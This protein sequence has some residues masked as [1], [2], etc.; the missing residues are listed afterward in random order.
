[1]KQD[2]LS[3][4]LKYILDFSLNVRYN[5]LCHLLEAK[6]S[7]IYLSLFIA[8]LTV[9]AFSCSPDPISSCPDNQVL[10][11]DT[12]ECVENTCLNH[13]CDSHQHCI[14]N[15]SGPKCI[16]DNGY[17]A[18]IEYIAGNEILTCSEHNN[19]I[20]CGQ[21]TDSNTHC[22]SNGEW[23]CNDG[24]YNNAAPGEE[25]VCITD[26][27]YAPNENKDNNCACNMGFQSIHD[28]CTQTE[29]PENSHRTLNTACV[30]DN[31]YIEVDGQC[32]M[33]M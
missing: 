32:L 12:N 5:A 8:L 19:T 17:D 13:F 7:K 24:Y 4:K 14:V 16:C 20:E 29:C 30:C 28:F 15:I 3:I 33:K 23:V 18:N 11:E 22:N 9:F 10:S 31:N 25:V 26:E 21:G 27:C 2:E 1:M 6:M